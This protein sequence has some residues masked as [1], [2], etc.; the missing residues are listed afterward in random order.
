MD[1]HTLLDPTV[2]SGIPAPWWLIQF[3]K[4]LGFVLH[5]VPMNLWYV[6]IALAV[7]LHWRGSQHGRQFAKR[8]I[9]QM[10]VWVALGIN[11]GI[12]PLLFVQL[13]YYKLFYPATILM[14]WPWMAVIALLLPAY[15]GVYVHASGMREDGPG[16]TPAR[17]A[18]GWVSAAAFLTIGF[19]F[20]NAFSLM[21]DPARW[22]PLWQQHN[23]AGAATGTALNW[24]DASFWPR[25]LLMLGLALQTT[26]VWAVVD[27]AWLARNESDAYRAWA[28]RFALRLFAVGAVWF[29]AA[30][31]WYVFGTWPKEL[32][33][34]M[35]SGATMGLMVLTAIASAV[36]LALLLLWRKG[37]LTLPAAAAV[38]AAQLGVLAVNGISRQVVQNAK[39]AHYFDTA[40]QPTAIEWSPLVLFVVFLIAGIGVIAWMVAQAVKA[41]ALPGSPDR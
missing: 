1:P 18:A 31:S 25:W 24:G 21:A 29:A 23:V 28:G 6:G 41:P 7:F 2:S 40:G 10:P 14:A 27:A 12:V 35:F 20:A 19:L 15:Y 33:D 30:G 39:I 36:P 32:F 5:M 38:G 3:F 22:V 8:L 13:A 34:G 17:Q 16:M 37:P 9:R 26:A 11:F 4:V